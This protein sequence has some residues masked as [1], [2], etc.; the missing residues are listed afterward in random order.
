LSAEEAVTALER[1]RPDAAI[2]D[3]SLPRINGLTVARQLVDSGIPLLIISGHPTYL[4]LL[5]EARC[6]FLAKP[7]RT[8]DLL[9][10][11]GPLLRDGKAQLAPVK[12]GLDRLAA[13]ES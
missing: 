3:A 5:T 7:F 9:A 12:A 6:P 11:L 4:D 8:D 13:T 2:I 10:A 1:R